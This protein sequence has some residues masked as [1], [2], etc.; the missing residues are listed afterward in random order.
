MSNP[1][2]DIA[3]D[4]I[5]PP[6]IVK[7]LR[8]LSWPVCLF[9]VAWIMLAVYWQWLVHVDGIFGEMWDTLPAYQLLGEMSVADI[10]H[11]LLRKYA[12]VHIIALPK[13]GFWID[14][15]FFGAA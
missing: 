3:K 7:I 14:F 10:A 6:D 13:L 15:N 9:A 4:E 5:S 1:R 11:E 8:S 12:F 2:S